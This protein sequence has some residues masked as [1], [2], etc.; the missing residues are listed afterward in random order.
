MSDCCGPYPGVG[1]EPKGLKD[2]DYSTY[3][4]GEVKLY[5]RPATPLSAIND[6]MLKEKIYAALDSNET[7]NNLNPESKEQVSG[8]IDDII[9]EIQRKTGE[10]V[11]L[12][13]LNGRITFTALGDDGAIYALPISIGGQSLYKQFG[14][15]MKSIGVIYGYAYEG[16]CY[17]LPKP[18]IMFLPK[19]ACTIGP[20]DCGCDCGYVPRLGYAVWQIDKLD[21]VVALDIRADDIKTLVLDA[22]LPGNR[23]PLAYA[24]DTGAGS[25]TWAN[26][27]IGPGNG[28]QFGWLHPPAAPKQL[29]TRQFVSVGSQA[30]SS[31]AFLIP[32]ERVTF[33]RCASTVRRESLSFSALSPLA[34]PCVIIANICCCR[35]VSETSARFAS[36][37]SDPRSP[38]R[39][40]ILLA[41]SRSTPSFPYDILHKRHSFQ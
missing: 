25:P 28:R 35:P 41:R 32:V 29:N 36:R 23:S 26:G 15:R 31:T 40:R 30:I 8:I 16:H 4:P 39:P 17:R 38:L 3:N 19:E 7:I 24:A 5:G 10:D 37:L 2:T 12:S 27:R 34:L 6:D 11:I 1:E 14:Q 13:L 18:Q 20:D 21:V 33:A 9:K 22:N